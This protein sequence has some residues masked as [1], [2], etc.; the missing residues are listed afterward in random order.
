[1]VML[2]Q[3]AVELPPYPDDNCPYCGQNAWG[4]RPDLSGYYC[5]GCVPAAKVF[6][7]YDAILL[8]DDVEPVLKQFKLM[9]SDEP[10]LKHMRSI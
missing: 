4:V 3:R 2:A 9:P 10:G 7:K 6:K 5:S 8:V 1:M